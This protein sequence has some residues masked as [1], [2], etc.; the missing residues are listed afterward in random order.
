M[1]RQY[2]KSGGLREIGMTKA[3]LMEGYQCT[4]MAP[5][6]LIPVAFFRKQA[7]LYAFSPDLSRYIGRTYWGDE[8]Y[9][10]GEECIRQHMSPGLVSGRDRG[11]GLGTAMYLG[12]CLSLSYNTCTYSIEGDRSAFADD[13][14][15][16]MNDHNLSTQEI[17]SI[18]HYFEEELDPSY[19]VDED[20]LGESVLEGRDIY[21]ARIDEIEV[22]GEIN[23]TV[24]AYSEAEVDNLKE[25]TILD[26]SGLVLHDDANRDFTPIPPDGLAV[27]DWKHTPYSLFQ[28]ILDAQ[29][30]MFDEGDDQVY[31]QMVAEQLRKR[32]KRMLAE[33]ALTTFN[34]T[35]R[36]TPKLRGPAIRVR[37]NSSKVR[38]EFQKLD[39]EWMAAYTKGNWP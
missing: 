25:E 5:K 21:D 16:S 8:M 32:K 12:G 18:N 22:S 30:R 14:W 6:S 24:S 37:N 28:D 19:Y 2:G 27:I 36:R 33:Y 1:A 34:E 39:K 26:S 20:T 15:Q 29:Y 9:V 35:S 17:S 13:A 38:K 11:R 7:T 10:D 23:V 3:Q 4:L 31:A